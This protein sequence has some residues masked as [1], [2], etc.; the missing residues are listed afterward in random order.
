MRPRRHDAASLKQLLESERVCTL[1][2]LMGAL[3]TRVRMTVFRKLS[4]LPY[5]TSYSHRGKY[6]TLRPLC[7]FDDRGLWSYREAWFSRHGTLRKTC[8]QFVECSDA[9]YSAAELDR[10]LHVPTQP[11]LRHLHQQQSLKREKFNGVFV[12]LSRHERER[13]GQRAA[14]RERVLEAVGGVSEVV[15]AHELKAAIVL[16]LGLLD[17]RQRRCYAGLESLRVGPGGDAKIAR[18]LGVDPHTVARGRRQLLAGDLAP[19]RI[20]K[21]GGGRPSAEKKHRR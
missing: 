15:L 10:A 12:Y 4:E 14:R 6:Y 18:L 19:G 16:F 17:E 5:L 7:R 21:P 2:D 3:G 20:R 8:Q 9:G 13:Q 1:D 11:A